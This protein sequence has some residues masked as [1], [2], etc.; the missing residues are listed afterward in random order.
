MDGNL[1]TVTICC[2]FLMTRNSTQKYH[3]KWFYLIIER[4][5]SKA[6][7]AKSVDF[8]SDNECHNSFQRSTFFA[9]SGQS[10]PLE[11]SHVHFNAGTI[12]EESFL[13]LKQFINN[14]FVIGYELS[15]QTKEILDAINIKYVDIWLHPIRF[16]DDNFYAYSSSDGN[17]L[18][19]LWKYNLP[20]DTYYLYADKLKIQSYMGWDK[21]YNAIDK[22]L[23]DDSCL[24]VGQT[25]TDKAVCRDGTMLTVLN[26]EE[27]FTQLTKDYSHVYFSPHP[28]IRG[29]YTAQLQFLNQ[30]DNVSII[31]EPGYKLLCS[32]KIKKVVA[33]SSSLVYEAKFFNKDTEFLYRPI[34]PVSNECGDGGYISIFNKLHSSVFWANILECEFETKENIIDIDYLTQKNNYRDMLSLYYNNKVFDKEHFIFESN[35][36]S[37]T[38]SMKPKDKQVKTASIQPYFSNMIAVQKIRE[39]M[40]K[41]KVVS[42]DI[43]DTVLQRKVSNPGDIPLLVAKYANKNFSISV[44]SYIN[45]RKKCK[46]FSSFTYETPLSERYK[47]MS[48]LLSIPEK[49]GKELYDYEME[50]DFN[51]IE[52]RQVGIELIKVARELNTRIVLASDI[53]YD[54]DF[55][56][57]LLDKCSIDYDELFVS[58]EI[59]K[60]KESGSLYDVLIEAFG[61]NI[62]HIGDNRHSDYNKAKDKKI[63][64]VLLLSNKEQI[65]RVIKPYTELTGDY[66]EFRNGLIQSKISQFPIITSEPGYTAGKPDHFGYN[67]VGDIFLAFAHWILCEAKKNNI[68]R[69]AFL[70]RDGEIIKKVFDKINTTDIG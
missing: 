31:K 63:T 30:F 2:D 26:F 51:L 40:K 42:L 38:G 33:I 10:L 52:P 6:I 3:L 44:D 25:L 19:K 35:K 46:E 65:K 8:L 29:D 69:I 15:E 22:I 16:L 13:Y 55:V 47:I 7:R 12:S 17:I 1:K 53:Y 54:R 66:K 56:I 67:V 24:F 20:D 59:D 5:L 18:E 68:K 49:W 39:M 28:M 37:N 32:E 70:A 36:V 27:E 64:P 58:S 34:V 50:L 11:E 14:T 9:L 45:A 21:F 61:S 62:L 4:A 41:Y 43:F 48:E 23:I 60:T 57:K